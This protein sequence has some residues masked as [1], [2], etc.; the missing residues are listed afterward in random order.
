VRSAAAF[1]IV[2]PQLPFSVLD[3]AAAPERPLA[4]RQ[5]PGA[6]EGETL[7]LPPA[8][9]V[10]GGAHDNGARA[11]IDHPQRATPIERVDQTVYL[12]L[13]PERLEWLVPYLREARFLGLLPHLM[14]L[15][16]LFPDDARD[17]DGV[18]RARLRRHGE[19]M[20]ELI[21]GL[22]IKLRLPNPDVAPDDL[23]TR[24][25]RTSLRGVLE[26][27]GRER[28]G[29]VSDMGGLLSLSGT[30]RHD[31]LGAAVGALEREPLMTATPWL[32][33]SIVMGTRLERDGEELGDFSTYR[34]LLQQTLA[35]MGRLSADEFLA[36]VHEPAD[37]RLDAEREA[38][39]D[40]L[41][42]QQRAPA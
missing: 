19:L 37:E 27:L 10:R 32:A 38:L 25:L 35:G 40:A 30:V 13:S 4:A 17:A 12:G 16:A 22:F 5:L 31:E 41:A 8:T 26:S 29:A 7:Q 3:A 39:I 23:E 42:E 33:L 14:L 20:S 18:L 11:T 9:P 2:E 21:D 15:R 24:E 34:S 36:A 1:Q 6:A 28:L